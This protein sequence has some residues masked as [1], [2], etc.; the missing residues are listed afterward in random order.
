MKNNKFVK[1]IYR[2]NEINRIDK[3]IAT[4]K[5]YPLD[6]IGFLNVRLSTTIMIF[7]I[8]LLTF[9]TGYILAPIFALLYYYL[10]EYIFLDTLVYKRIKKTPKA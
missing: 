2:E 8:I 10:F 4:L 7:F 6:T 3:K 5:N 9:R 1:R